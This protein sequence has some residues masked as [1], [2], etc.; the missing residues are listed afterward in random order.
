M[1]WLSAY[2]V[3]TVRLIISICNGQGAYSI[4]TAD[5][6]GNV[7]YL[8]SDRGDK[9]DDIAKVTQDRRN[10]ESSSAFKYV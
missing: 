5:V 8:H 3:R 10:I 1:Y 9:S 6:E 7:V 2:V 4:K